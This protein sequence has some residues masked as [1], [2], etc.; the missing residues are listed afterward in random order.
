MDENEEKPKKK[1]GRACDHIR[2]A[3]KRCLRESDCVQKEHRQALDC[4]HSRADTVPARCFQLLDV[5]AQCK[6]SLIDNRLR[7]RGR[8]LD[9]PDTETFPE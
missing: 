2:Q 8:K 1:T 9:I 7:A 6:L 3:L 4:L 5:F